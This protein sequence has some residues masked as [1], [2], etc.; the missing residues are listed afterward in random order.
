MT[1]ALRALLFAT[2][3]TLA[4]CAATDSGTGNPLGAGGFPSTGFGGQGGAGIG[5]QGTAGVAGFGAGGSV[6]GAGMGAA[7][8]AGIPRAGAGGLGGGA[9]AAPIAGASAGTGGMAGTAGAGGMAGTAG[10]GTGGASGSTPGTVTVEFTT[11]S[12]GGEYAPLNYGAVWFEE[13]GGEFVKTA[14]RWA[15]ALHATDLVGW[16]EAS[17]GWGSIFGGGNMA[18]QMDAVSSATIRTHQAHTV[19]WNMKDAEGQLVPDGP[20]V[21]VLEMS[22]SRARDRAGPVIRIPFMKGPSPQTANQPAQEGFTGAML[23]YEP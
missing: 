4:A 20:Y 21:A 9:G 18:D 12:Y 11:V 10:A 15:G 23:R 16:T 13:D 7:G 6:A 8:A 17:G 5:G 22:E 19:M 2:A 1:R 3:L 14:K